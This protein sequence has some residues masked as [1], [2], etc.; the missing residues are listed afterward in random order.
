MESIKMLIRKIKDG[1]IHEMWEEFK[2]MCSYG[3]NYKKEIFFYICLGIFSTIMS[4]VSSIASKNLINIV[5]GIQTDKAASMAI[6]MVSMA[7]FSDHAEDQHQD[8]E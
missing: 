5:T 8:P 7:L 1:S 4:L 6:I 2:W 3:K